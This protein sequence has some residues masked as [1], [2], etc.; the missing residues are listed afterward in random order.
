MNLVCLSEF[1]KDF[2]FIETFLMSCRVLGR[3][4][5]SWTLNE[6]KKI[7]I[8]NKFQYLIGQYIHSDKK[9][10]LFQNI[11]KY[12]NGDN[13]YYIKLDDLK[14]NGLEIYE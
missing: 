7:G 11:S 10:K 2:V 6:I 1:D 3:S 4:L 12:L 13:Y 5:E 9:S 8:K 14:I